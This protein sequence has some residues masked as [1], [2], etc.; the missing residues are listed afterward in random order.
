[1][2]STSPSSKLR[3]GEQKLFGPVGCEACSSTGYR[4]RVGIH[5]LL[6]NS[7][8]LKKVIYAKGRATE[9]R[10]VAMKQGMSTLMQDGIRKMINGQTDLD[11]VRRVALA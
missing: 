9:I 10:E 8:E 11:E 6:V 2:R 5:E 1:M 7:E 4:S 3:P